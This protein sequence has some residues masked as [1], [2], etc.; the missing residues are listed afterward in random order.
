MA[1]KPDSASTDIAALV[2]DPGFTPGVRRLGD[3]LGLVGGNDDTIGKHAERAVLRIETQYA[4]RVTDE[5]V[6]GARGASR[7]ARARLTHLVGRL[8][9]EK[10]DPEGQ[11]LAWL[12][13]A[14]ADSDPKT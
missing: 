4:K 6:A 2:A 13:E 3:L 9:Q 12:L 10:R 8:A 5:T 11:A 1:S 14:L 7:P